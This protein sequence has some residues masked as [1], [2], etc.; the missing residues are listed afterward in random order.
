MIYFKETIFPHPILYNNCSDYISNKFELDVELSQN[1][2]YYIFEIS[3]EINSEFIMNLIKEGRVKKFLIIKTDDTSFFELSEGNKL[4]INVKKISLNSKTKVQLFLQAKEDIS[5]DKNEDLNIF[6][7]DYKDQIIIK[8]GMCIAF[9]NVI[10]YE[11]S[12]NNPFDLFEKNLNSNLKSDLKVNL[13][14]QSIVIEYKN[15]DSFFFDVDKKSIINT[16]LYIGLQKALINFLSE[17]SEEK[18]VDANVFFE[19][20]EDIEEDFTL[21]GKLIKL[22][23][24]KKV[25]SLSLDNLD[26]VIHLISDGMIRKYVQAVRGLYERD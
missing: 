2:E 16:Y 23:K 15:Q 24:S 10:E 25:Q 12:K 17:N 20:L 1:S 22:L 13:T 14:E 5:F 11:G 19:D 3:Y 9:S 7:N 6:Y 4:E 18:L 21:N 8:K 26:E